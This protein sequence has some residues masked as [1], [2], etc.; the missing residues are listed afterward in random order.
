MMAA[1]CTSCDLRQS[2]HT[3]G[4]AVRCSAFQPVE[5]VGRVEQSSD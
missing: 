4:S 3:K 5:L 1:E 2:H